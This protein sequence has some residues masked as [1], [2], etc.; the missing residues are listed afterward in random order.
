MESAARARTVIIVE[1]ESDKVAL[2][3]LA[4]RR[5]LALA[6]AGV[7]IMAIGGAHAI[8][9]LVLALRRER[10]EVVLR[11]LSDEREEPNFRRALER[12]GFGRD[13]DSAGLE[14]V[15]E[16]QGELPS[17]R[18]LQ[19]QPAQ[20]GRS[21]IQH[22]RRFI[23]TRSGRR[24]QYARAMVLALDLNRMPRPLDAVLGS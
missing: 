11:G 13:L 16:A 22:L 1:G 23:S 8:G 19:A 5:G 17:L 14:R 21:S 4:Q 10:P 20:R 18:R 6:S 7:E 12:A 3:T 2:E 9:R 15:I 24:A